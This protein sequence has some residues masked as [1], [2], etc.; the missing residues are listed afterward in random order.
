M[1]ATFVNVGI[2]DLATLTQG[3]FTTY[4]IAL[5]TVGPTIGVTNVWTSFTEATF[6]GY[7]RA[8]CTVGAP[9][10][11]AGL[12]TMAVTPVTFTHDSSVSPET[13]KGYAVVDTAFSPY[14]LIL[15]EDFS[16]PKVMAVSGDSIT[17]TPTLTEH[18][19]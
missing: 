18:Q 17:L 11:S 19:G 16:V 13:I 8:N 4:K 9:S 1:A 7:A 5:Y 10:T 12:A 14:H 6:G 3:L 15:A 2:N